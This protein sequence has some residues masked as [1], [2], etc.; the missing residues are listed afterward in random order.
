MNGAR[1][2]SKKRRQLLVS[3]RKQLAAIIKS[4][5]VLWNSTN[6]QYRD[7]AAHEAAWQEVAKEMDKTIE[8]C[9]LQWRSLRDS[10]RHRHIMGEKMK[11][12]GNIDDPLE[13]VHDPDWEFAEDLK[14]LSYAP[15]R[16]KRKRKYIIIEDDG[17]RDALNHDESTESSFVIKNEA[18]DDGLSCK[19][20]TLEEVEDA[21]MQ[22]EVDGTAQFLD[23]IEQPLEHSTVGIGTS[24]LVNQ[25][26]TLVQAQTE[27][28]REFKS[29]NTNNFTFK[30][31]LIAVDALLQQLPKNIALKTLIEM[32]NYVLKKVNE[33]QHNKSDSNI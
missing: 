24:H 20:P 19:R 3:E 27:F 23:F 7:P 2:E 10:Y 18:P 11:S 21:Y 30:T 32:Q 29:N 33:N 16:R 28:L 22:Q 6:A 17:E 4:K 15:R 14:F 13:Y 5:E 12:R 8:M 9:K 25:L 1:R 26:G 31:Q